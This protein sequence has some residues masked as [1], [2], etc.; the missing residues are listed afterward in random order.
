MVDPT[1]PVA[2]ALVPLVAEVAAR[3]TK[4]IPWVKARP[5]WVRAG[6][7]R[8]ASVAA[9]LAARFGL[10]VLVGLLGWGPGLGATTGPGLLLLAVEGLAEVAAGFGLYRIRKET[11]KSKS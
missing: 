11:A 10:V 6:L 7:I 5:R 2:V 8:T 1:A 9:G 4:A 3:V